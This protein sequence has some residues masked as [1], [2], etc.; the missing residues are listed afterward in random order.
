M[1]PTA[2]RATLRVNLS[3]PLD[4]VAILDRIGAVTGAGRATL[5]REFLHEAAPNFVQVAQALELAKN[6]NLDAFKVLSN[7][8]DSQIAQ[9]QQLSLDIKKTRRRAMRRKPL[10]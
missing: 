7:S 9:S 2:D 1:K 6:R 5:I 8:L 4:L 10:P 3:L